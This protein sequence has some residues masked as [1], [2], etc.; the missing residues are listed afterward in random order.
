M[1]YLAGGKSDGMAFVNDWLA[2]NI[3]V[4]TTCLMQP[5]R[6]GFTSGD[7]TRLTKHLRL[8]N[9]IKE[10]EYQPAPENRRDG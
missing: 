3:A 2:I 8:A 5:S 10:R 1:K 9:Q 6:S 4:L 7:G